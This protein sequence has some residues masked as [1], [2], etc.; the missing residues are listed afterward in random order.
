M[1][2]NYNEIIERMTKQ[3][4]GSIS[5]K[6]AIANGIPPATFARYVQ[7][8]KLI[9][10]RPGVYATDAALIDDFFQLQKRYP[11]IVYSGMTALYLLGL[12]DRI[13]DLI[14]FTMPKNYRIRKG[15]NDLSVICHIENKVHLFQKGN[16][17]VKTMFGNEVCCFSK[18]KMV[19]EMIWKRNEYDSELFLKAIKTFLRKNDKDMDFLFEYAK[20]RKIEEKVYQVLEAMNY[21]N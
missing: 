7:C 9:K 5:R 13:P 21:E 11:K 10:I 17:M 18:E 16:I 12:T 20:M 19:V 8:N 1:N 3:G 14:E 6:D 2:Q 4:D 15:K